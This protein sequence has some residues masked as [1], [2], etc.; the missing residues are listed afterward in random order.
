MRPRCPGTGGAIAPGILACALLA[1][2][3]GVSAGVAR[4]A[5][6]VRYRDGLL[7][8][9]AE[10]EPAATV[11]AAVGKRAGIEVVVADAVAAIPVT[12]RIRGLPLEDAL[13]RLLRAIG[14][15]GHVLVYARD[16]RPQRLVVLE[17]D[18]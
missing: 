14:R 17:D 8:L 7:W 1:C 15:P 5:S 18:S 4:A 12:L 2:T 10:N 11:F 9:T 3:L 13:D 16:G 6:D